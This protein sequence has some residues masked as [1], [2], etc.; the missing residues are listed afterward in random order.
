MIYLVRYSAPQDVTNP[1]YDG[2]MIGFPLSFVP[3]EFVGA[4]E[5]EAQT[6]EHRVVVRI[7]GSTIAVWRLADENLEHVA[8]YYARKF[9]KESLE[10]NTKFDSYTV[11]GP[12][13]S[14][15]VTPGSCPFDPKRV[16]APA[17][18]TEKIEIQ[19]RMG[20]GGC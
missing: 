1:S 8:F 4:P 19:K 20:F 9:V 16:P 11:D 10:K 12:L 3:D 17:G 5:E 15:H 6:H 7:D 18:F 14:V 2:R 13:V